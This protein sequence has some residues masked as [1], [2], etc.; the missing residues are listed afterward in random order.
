MQR[1]DF[2]R[3]LALLAAGASFDPE[4]MLWTPK[5]IITVPAMPW[6]YYISS[7]DLALKEHY[8]PVF[9]QKLAQ[10]R[11]LTMNHINKQLYGASK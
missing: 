9:E 8:A 2:L 5:T 11:L 4:Q 7:F 6:R 10:Q 3:G 1:R